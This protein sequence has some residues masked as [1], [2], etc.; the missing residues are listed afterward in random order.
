[1]WPKCRTITLARMLRER[2]TPRGRCKGAYKARAFHGQYPSGWPAARRLRAFS[3][4]ETI[5][6]A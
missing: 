1:M 4:H 5:P 2:D 6:I 3:A